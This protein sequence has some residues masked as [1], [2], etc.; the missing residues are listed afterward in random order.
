[1]CTTF[2]L[3]IHIDHYYI[4]LHG[5]APSGAGR[6]LMCTSSVLVAAKGYLHAFMQLLPHS[7][8]SL[9]KVLLPHR[10][11]RAMHF[12]AAAAAFQTM[13]PLLQDWKSYT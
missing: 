8:Y 1:M 3:Q 11:M 10:Q 5:N 6:G 4:N 9:C 12:T 7:L 13:T 2:S